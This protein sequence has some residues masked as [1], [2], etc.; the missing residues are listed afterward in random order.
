MKPEFVAPLVLY[1]CS[2]QCP[3]TGATYNAG[4]GYFNRAAIA[5]GPGAVVGDGKAAPLRLRPWRRVSKKS[6]SLDHGEKYPNAT[7]AFGPMLD[8]F[9]PKKAEGAGEKEAGLTVQTHF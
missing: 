8:A 5:T 6:K 1:L 9:S 3:V 4:M 7:A 2:E